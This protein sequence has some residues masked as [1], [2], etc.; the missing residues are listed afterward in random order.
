M[1]Q[2]PCTDRHHRLLSRT[3]RTA[4]KIMTSSIIDPLMPTST[5]NKK[6]EINTAGSLKTTLFPGASGRRRRGGGGFMTRFPKPLP[7]L[8]FR[9]KLTCGIPSPVPALNQ[10]LNDRCYTITTRRI[11]SLRNCTLLHLRRASDIYKIAL[12]KIW[13]TRTLNF[14]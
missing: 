4:R 3:D 1:L 14:F 9:S 11:T 2:D 13:T 7:Y 8:I 12:L 10:S 6:Y 5:R